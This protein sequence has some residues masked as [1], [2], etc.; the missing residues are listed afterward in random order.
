MNFLFLLKLDIEGFHILHMLKHSLVLA[1]LSDHWCSAWR[2]YCPFWETVM[3]PWLVL[4][5][6]NLS[7]S[8]SPLLSLTFALPQCIWGWLVCLITV[9]Y[10]DVKLVSARSLQI[11]L[12]FIVAGVA[13]GWSGLHT[14]APGKGEKRKNR[15]AS[16]GNPF[17]LMRRSLC[18]H[19][20][21]HHPKFS[22]W[23]PHPTH[24]PACVSSLHHWLL[25]TIP[26][27]KIAARMLESVACGM[28]RKIL[29]TPSSSCFCL[30][31]RLVS[32]AA[33]GCPQLLWMRS[34][35]E[36]HAVR[37][38]SSLT[39]WKPPVPCRFL[40]SLLFAITI[41]CISRERG[42]GGY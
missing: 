33:S 31:V 11:R 22:S 40:S 26:P 8:L 34:L 30:Q 14:V 27:P 1:N 13:V 42:T 18:Q 28:L 4:M 41:L 3:L 37:V 24:Q 21:D 9:E 23:Y 2:T 7:L 38:L 29:S 19:R 10:A 36:V 6:V 25:K 39:L 35:E 32:G 16:W 20:G 12:L 5:D 17:P 15:P